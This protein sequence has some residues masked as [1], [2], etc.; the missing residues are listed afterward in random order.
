MRQRRKERH[1]AASGQV[2]AAVLAEVLAVVESFVRVWL[3]ASQSPPSRLLAPAE[4]AA[5][6]Q[7]FD[8]LDRWD[9]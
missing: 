6:R 3:G 9:L 7:F 1:L 2:L 5:L 4:I 8:L